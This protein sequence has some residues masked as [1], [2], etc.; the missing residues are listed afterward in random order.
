MCVCVRVC[1]VPIL[2]R[3]L[4]IM[5]EALCKELEKFLPSTLEGLRNNIKPQKATRDINRVL[6]N[7]GIESRV[8]DKVKKHEL[9]AVITR[10]CTLAA[11][12][13]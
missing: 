1:E 6:C 8:D 12:T 4:V 2:P 11:Q 7:Y 5:F 3:F 9:L 10:Q 13:S